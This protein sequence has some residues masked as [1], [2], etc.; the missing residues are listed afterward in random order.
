M[1]SS[2]HMLPVSYFNCNIYRLLFGLPVDIFH[3]SNHC[4]N[5]NLTIEMTVSLSLLW[6]PSTNEVGTFCHNHRRH[7]DKWCTRLLRVAL[8]NSIWG[9]GFVKFWYFST[10]FTFFFWVLGCSL[11]VV[12]SAN[13]LGNTPCISTKK[14]PLWTYL[15][16]RRSVI[17]KVKDELHRI[18]IQLFLIQILSCYNQAVTEYRSLEQA[19]EFKSFFSNF[20]CG[21]TTFTK[22]IV[23]RDVFVS[24]PPSG[25][26]TP[27]LETLSNSH[28]LG[29]YCP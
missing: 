27:R 19:T 4:C 14:N 13:S 8:S 9:L 29:V 22:I 23:H 2:C 25:A 15:W 18:L 3:S 10:R 26:L 12:S 1:F 6:L 11:L 16:L 21:Q 28:G 17:L 24:L 7:C 20:S 5:G